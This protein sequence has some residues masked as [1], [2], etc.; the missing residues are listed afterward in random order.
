MGQTNAL[1]RTHWVFDW[2]RLGI[3]VTKWKLFLLSKT[4]KER[5][6]YLLS[7][8]NISKEVID[9][10]AESSSSRLS[11]INDYLYYIWEYLQI[12]ESIFD[13]I[14][15]RDAYD[16]YCDELYE[17]VTNGDNY[18]CVLLDTVQ[19]VLRKDEAR[20][21][22][23]A[24]MLEERIE[25]VVSTRIPNLRFPPR[26]S[27]RWLVFIAPHL[28]DD[29]KDMLTYCQEILEEFGRPAP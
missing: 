20:V 27:A 28:N 3:G 16:S 22:P 26:G 1:A 8:I 2:S 12:D 4:Q 6:D 10:P 24:I 17:F 14:I 29:E 7:S 21:I 5:I 13:G 18:D 11:S 19:R 23:I 15:S 25:L 9:H